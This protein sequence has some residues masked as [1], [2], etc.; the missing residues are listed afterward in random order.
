[1]TFVAVRN[2]EGHWAYFHQGKK[3]EWAMGK[4]EENEDED[5]EGAG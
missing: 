4:E 3:V 5:V 1:M 2:M